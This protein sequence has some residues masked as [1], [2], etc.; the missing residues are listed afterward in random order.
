MPQL[1]KVSEVA[2]AMSSTDVS[3]MDPAIESAISR[4][5]IKVENFLKTSLAACEVTDLFYVNDYTGEPLDGYYRL[6]LSN[7]FVRGSV[8]VS[9]MLGVSGD[10]T[11]SAGALFDLQRGVV[12]VPVAE[13]GRYVSATYRSGY[14]PD[15]VIHERVKQAVICFTPLLLLTASSNQIEAKVLQSAM[16]RATALDSSGE[17]MLLG[18]HRKVGAAIHPVNSTITYLTSWT[19]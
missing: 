11:A 12:R 2:E 3:G 5:I 10:P 1:V 16:D 7:G 15:D 9:S 17:A 14:L 13:A 4:A 8:S 19:P 18:L 6:V